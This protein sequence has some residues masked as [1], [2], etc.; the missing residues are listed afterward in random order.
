M[1]KMAAII[2]SCITAASLVIAVIIIAI[3]SLRKQWVEDQVRH[4]IV[5][6]HII[7]VC[8]TEIF[9]LV[10]RKNVKHWLM[11]AQKFLF[12]FVFFMNCDYK[13]TIQIREGLNLLSDCLTDAVL[14]GLGLWSSQSAQKNWISCTLHE[15]IL[16][17][18]WTAS[19]KIS[20]CTHRAYCSC[21]DD[22]IP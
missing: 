5:F 21:F 7:G 20:V 6:L 16:S 14:V 2:V 22:N 10:V 19:L 18:S 11:N 17:F 12:L 3:I 8:T 4:W 9:N 1:S 13:H 15:R